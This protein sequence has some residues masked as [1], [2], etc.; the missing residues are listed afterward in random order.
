MKSAPLTDVIPH[1]CGMARA[2]RLRNLVFV[3]KAFFD[4]SGLNPYEDKVLVMGG[5]LGSVDEWE[6]VSDAWD[7][8]LNRAPAIRYFKSDEANGLNG[9]FERFNHAS[10][11]EKRKELAGIVGGSDLQGICASVLHALFEGRNPKLAKGMVGSR[12]YDWGFFTA[13]SGTLQYVQTVHP[14]ET[15]DF[16]FDKRTELRSCIAI[17]DEM[18]EME[19]CPWSA[20]MRVAGACIPGDDEKVVALQISDL[21]AGEFSSMANGGNSPSEAWKLLTAR[22]SVAHIPC[23][24]PPSVPFLTGLRSFGKEIRDATGRFLQRFYK[25][26]ERSISLLNDLGEIAERKAIFDA[27]MKLLSGRYESDPDFL[28]FRERQREEK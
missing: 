18:K 13:T 23:R 10:A 14:G 9:Q 24:L 3:M 22:H 15:I 17:Y 11:D 16:I 4:E 19:D 1:L 5:F 21:L 28:K 7:A 6:R 2:Y 27:A 26:N 20:I 25:E 8:C 12:V